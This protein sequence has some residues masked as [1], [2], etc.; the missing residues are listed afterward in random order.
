M[1]S[2][3]LRKDVTRAE[4]QIEENS[5]KQ[6]E[7]SRSANDFDAKYKAS[8]KEL[9]I[10]G[11]DL[12]QLAKEIRN[13]AHTLLPVVFEEVIIMTKEKSVQEAV[14]YYNEYVKFILQASDL[15]GE[16]VNLPTILFI[17]EYG[18][19]SCQKLIE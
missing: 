4:Q 12:K 18:N 11:K 1:Y 7:Y 14:G 8:C 16:E 5:K 3:A 15:K 2:P 6:M 13:T 9:G 17:G 10:E 19:A